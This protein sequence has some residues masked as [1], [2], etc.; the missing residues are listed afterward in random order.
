MPSLISSGEISIEAHM[1]TA[2]DLPCSRLYMMSVNRS[3]FLVELQSA[4]RPA[5]LNLECSLIIIIQSRQ[6][7]DKRAIFRIYHLGNIAS[8]GSIA[9]VA[10]CR[11]DKECRMRK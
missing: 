10:H 6:M 8:V 5:M 2:N 11:A 4:G 7:D 3:G 9:I 1:F